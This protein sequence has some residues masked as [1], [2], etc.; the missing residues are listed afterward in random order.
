MKPLAD[1]STLSN[2]DGS[3]HRIRTGRSL[4]LRR[5]T[6]RQGHIV[7][8]SCA[9]RHR[10]LRPLEGFLGAGLARF[11]GCDAFVIFTL[12]TRTVTGLLDATALASASA[13]AACAA[14]NRAIATRKGEQLT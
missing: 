8:I 9:V 4:A 3:N 14:A 13:I 2:H 11:T 12:F 10:F 6:K 5:K 7:E 1:D